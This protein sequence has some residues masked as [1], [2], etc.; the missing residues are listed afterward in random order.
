MIGLT[1]AGPELAWL[2]RVLVT[3]S[4]GGRPGGDSYLK[5]DRRFNGERGREA[6]LWVGTQLGVLGARDGLQRL[7]QEPL[8]IL[9]PDTVLPPLFISSPRSTGP[10]LSRRFIET[11]IE[12]LTQFLSSYPE[13]PRA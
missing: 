9:H 2:T 4:R 1:P 13:W 7:R 5:G 10:S 3:P 11:E 6:K 12:M 8:P